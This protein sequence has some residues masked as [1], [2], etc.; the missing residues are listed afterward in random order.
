MAEELTVRPSLRKAKLGLV[1]AAAVFF[2]ITYAWWLFRDQVAWWILVV[3]ILP[4]IAPLVG[5][6]DHRRTCLTLTGRILS[7]HR[8]FVA[9]STERIDVAK[10]QNVRVE[11]T[12][13]DRMWGVG[14]LVI[15]TASESGRLVIQQIDNP[16]KVADLI[17]GAGVAQPG[18][19][20]PPLTPQAPPGEEQHG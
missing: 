14:T 1:I 3:G 4:F 11:R 17:L 8:G 15:E 16:T 6:I 7:V 10:V 20:A 13:V 5:W 9:T 12:M 18:S 2:S 19:P